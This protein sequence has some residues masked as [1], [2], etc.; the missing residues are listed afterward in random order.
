MPQKVQFS[1]AE[2]SFGWRQF[3]V[4]LTQSSEKFSECAN[5][6]LRRG[7]KSDSV[8]QIHDNMFETVSYT[9]HETLETAWCGGSALW[10]SKPLIEP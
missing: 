10:H 7:V 8:I 6:R 9:L 5:V 4:M 3:Q 2:S 1:G